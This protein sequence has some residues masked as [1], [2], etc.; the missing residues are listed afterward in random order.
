MS[1]V[2]FREQILPRTFEYTLSYLI[3]YELDRPAFDEHY[4]NDDTGRPVYD[5]ALL[6]KIALYAYARG[7]VSSRHIERC[8]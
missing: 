3:D 4:C 1:P 7:I 2:S 5:R 6:L 8:C